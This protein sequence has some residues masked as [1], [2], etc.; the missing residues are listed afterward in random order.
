MGEL[1]GPVVPGVEVGLGVGVDEPEVVPPVEEVGGVVEPL[2]PE[3]EPPE[4]NDK[5]EVLAA[6]K[7]Q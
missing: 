6:R 4:G 5:H 3:A 1:V 2:A 7:R